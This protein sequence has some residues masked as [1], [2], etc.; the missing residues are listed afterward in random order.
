MRH[1]L[2]KMAY[3]KEENKDIKIVII[4][5]ESEDSRIEETF[6]VKQ[7]ETEEKTGQFYSQS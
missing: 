3:I 7:E 1:N 5:E 2:I 6:S 4:K